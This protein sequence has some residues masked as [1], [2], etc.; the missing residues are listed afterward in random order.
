MRQRKF[1]WRCRVASWLFLLCALLFSVRWV[2]LSSSYYQRIWQR[3]SIGAEAG[4]D[5]ANQAQIARA[6]PQALSGDVDALRFSA[7][8]FGV[9]QPAF[10]DKEIA[11][12]QDVAGLFRL[13]DIALLVGG[14]LLVLLI[15]W[16]WRWPNIN[17]SRRRGAYWGCVDVV[18]LVAVVGILAAIDFRA[19]FWRF[20]EL[21]FT[22]DLWL[23]NPDTDL[24]IRLMPLRFFIITVLEIGLR[25]LGLAAFWL[26]V[27]LPTPA[28]IAWNKEER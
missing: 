25:W 17:V 28:Q 20:H 10:N 16:L 19:L 21:F 7:T 6:L 9:T 5:H 12:M 26:A 11:H 15:F 27:W 18:L 23:L 3:L 1:S 8:V 13:L 14:A 4:V 24:L 22:N 2:A